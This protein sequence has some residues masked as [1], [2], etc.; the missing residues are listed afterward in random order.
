MERKEVVRVIRWAFETTGPDQAEVRNYTAEL[1]QK[2]KEILNGRVLRRLSW[3][4]M[5]EEYYYSERQM[6]NILNTAL[7]RVGL[8]LERR[9]PRYA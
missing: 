4:S 8:Q 5:Q 7:D 6:R 9:R 3:S 1:S 2:E